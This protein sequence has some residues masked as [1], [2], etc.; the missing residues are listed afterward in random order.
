LNPSLGLVGVFEADHTGGGT[1]SVT[2]YGTARTYRVLTNN[3]SVGC[4]VW[5]TTST[6]PAILYV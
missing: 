5:Q 3:T 1:A 2:H 4:G 6:K